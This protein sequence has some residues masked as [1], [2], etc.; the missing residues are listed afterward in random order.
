M[1]WGKLSR[2]EQIEKMGDVLARAYADAE[3]IVNLEAVGPHL[4]DATSEMVKELAETK[5]AFRGALLTLMA[6]K[7]CDP[8]QDVRAHKAE[9]KGG[10][11]ART[12]DT[13]ATIP[14]LIEKTLPRSVETHW[15]TQ[16]LSFAGPLHE[17]TELKTQPRKVGPLFLQA[18]HVGNSDPSG[19]TAYAV[20]VTALQCL[21][22]A[23]NRDRVVLTRPK[24]LP[25]SSVSKLLERHFS[26]RYKTGGPRLPQVAIFALYQC[27]MESVNRY[28]GLSLE[29]LQRMKSAD[30]KA[31]TVGDVVVAQNE[32]PVEGVET[33]HGQPVRSI[34]V[35]EAMEKVRSERVSRYYVLSTGGV[36]ADD[37]EE[38]DSLV[39]AFRQQN[40]CE[41]IVNG[42]VETI[43]YYLRLLPDTSSFLAN[44]A[45]I[46]ETDEDLGYEHRIGWNDACREV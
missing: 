17:E 7:C 24:N 1:N 4:P 26:R 12:Y 44:Y 11:S 14:F 41:M 29:P 20:L 35:H 15:L 37:Q 46:V 45:E 32:T 31:G 28:E 22:E 43:A 2:P 42:V 39:E 5:H 33:K 3:A 6:Y 13:S 36:L 38:I 16:T 30:R 23:R 25:I 10:F 27:L 18:V 34:N 9:H 8:S 19:E 40:G 21:I